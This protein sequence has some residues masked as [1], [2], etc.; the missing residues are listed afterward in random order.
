VLA[1]EAAF[2]CAYRNSISWKSPTDPLPMQNNPRLV[3]EKLFGDGNSTA[4]RRSRRQESRS[5]LDSVM[6]QSHHCRPI[7]LRTIDGA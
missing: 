5:L 7:S 3:F 1:C 4:E 2:S 6:S